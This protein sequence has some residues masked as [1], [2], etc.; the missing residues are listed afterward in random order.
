MN[1]II[2]QIGTQTREINLFGE[3]NTKL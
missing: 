1:E 2:L 3:N